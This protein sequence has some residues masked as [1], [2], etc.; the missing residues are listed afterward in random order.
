MG[1]GTW[2]A[3][4]FTHFNTKVHSQDYAASPHPTPSATSLVTLISL[5]Q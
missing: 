2:K 1:G 4:A 3:T 5:P